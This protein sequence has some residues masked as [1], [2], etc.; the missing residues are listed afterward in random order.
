MNEFAFKS[1]L[2]DN[3]AWFYHETT[4]WNQICNCG[5]VCAAL[6]TYESN[7]EI[8]RNII[9]KAVQSNLPTMKAAYS[10]DGNYPEGPQYWGYGTIHQCL[11]LTLM[12][13]CLG[14][15]FGLDSV[16]GFD[17]TAEF[18]LFSLGT[19]GQYFN[20]YDNGARRS[21]HPAMWYFAYRFNNPSFMLDELEILKENPERYAFSAG[22]GP[23]LLY[24]ASN[25]EL[26]DIHA[27]GTTSFAGR[28]KTPVLQARTGWSGSSEDKYLG[29][30]GGRAI[31][32]HGHLD[33]GEFVFDAWGVRWSADLGSESYAIVE[34]KFGEM[35]KD[36]WNMGAKLDLKDLFNGDLT[37]AERTVL[38][39]D[40][41][42]LEVTDAIEAP[43][44]KNASVRWT[45]VTEGKPE[46]TSKGIIL[47]KN[48]VEVL[49]SAKGHEVEYSIWS[50]APEFDFESKNDGYY[51]CGYTVFLKPGE[52]TELCTTLTKL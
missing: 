1:S 49:L 10:P 46:I 44:E 23:L 14:T 8:S 39:K 51:I 32:S 36:M 41:Q 28:G 35:G 40:N 37:K 33:S 13:S 7:P 22:Y 18:V 6:A 52:N 48:G 11:L 29:V 34:K 26:K 2:N 31:I 20:F 27:P 9:D 12:D 4:N 42:Y 43:A 47:S 38:L 21:P 15:N 50:S 19:T 5:L 3:W 16:E 45:I 17:K 30:K 25:I 24:Y